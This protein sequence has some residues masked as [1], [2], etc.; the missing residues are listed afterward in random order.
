MMRMQEQYIINGPL[1]RNLLSLQFPRAMGIAFQPTGV[2]LCWCGE[3]SLAR[4]L[5]VFF[6]AGSGCLQVRAWTRGEQHA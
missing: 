5:G 1:C 3:I 2:F 6:G 4:G